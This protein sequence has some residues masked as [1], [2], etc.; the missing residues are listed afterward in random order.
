MGVHSREEMGQKN[1]FLLKFC[2]LSL[3]LYMFWGR[4]IIFH[5]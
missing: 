3:A 4:F 1:L 5:W 2:I